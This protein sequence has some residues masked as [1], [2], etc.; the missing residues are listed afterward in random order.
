MFDKSLLR[1]SRGLSSSSESSNIKYY[2]NKFQ[3]LVLFSDS[4]ILKTASSNFCFTYFLSQRAYE[5][6]VSKDATVERRRKQK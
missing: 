4:L 3:S 6:V 1:K 5:A 2:R